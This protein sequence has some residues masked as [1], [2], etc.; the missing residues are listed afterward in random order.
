V[1][2]RSL[3]I[4]GNDSGPPEWAAPPEGAEPDEHDDLDIA[5]YELADIQA[6]AGRRGGGGMSWVYAVPTTAADLRIVI[7]DAAEVPFI[8]P[9]ESVKQLPTLSEL[10]H[11]LDGTKVDGEPWA[12][13]H[14]TGYGETRHREEPC[15]S[16]VQSKLY[17][18]L[19]ALYED[20]LEEWIAEKP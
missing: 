2:P 10:L 15:Y 7:V 20:R 11:I 3:L 8:S 17:P 6:S 16:V 13:W 14:P 18:Q 1:I 5:V 19:E 9:I 12:V 4:G